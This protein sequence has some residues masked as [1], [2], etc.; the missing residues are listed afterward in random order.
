MAYILE[1]MLKRRKKRKGQVRVPHK[2]IIQVISRGLLK[3]KRG[4]LS[5]DIEM[6][7]KINVG[8]SID[9]LLD[10]G[11]LSA[12]SKTE[13][14]VG[15]KRLCGATEKISVNFN[16]ENMKISPCTTVFIWYLYFQFFH[17]LP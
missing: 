10:D 1:S 9:A 2:Y 15:E 8:A 17:L 14:P 6:D 4:F 12:P 13:I 3:S 16:I 11:V 5:C 7:T